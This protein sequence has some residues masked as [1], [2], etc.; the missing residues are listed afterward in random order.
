MKAYVHGPLFMWNL[1][2]SVGKLAQNSDATVVSYIQWYYTLAAEHPDTP[3]E[4]KQV[5]RNVRVTGSCS[6]RD[7]DPL[8]QSI[9]IHQRDL[10]HPIV[11]GRINPAPGFSGDVR[12]G[13]DKAL[14]VVRL[15]ARL[16]TMFPQRWPRLDMMP[17]CPENVARAVQ[18]AIPEVTPS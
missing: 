3:T 9:L 15:G 16:A 17:R 13:N 6:G 1:S 4:R 12:I 7:D 8:V 2:I 10:N 18:E 11:D 14:F 5:Y